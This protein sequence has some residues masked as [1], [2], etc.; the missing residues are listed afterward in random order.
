[1]EPG[2]DGLI[3]ISDLSWTEQINHP[4]EIIDK[5]EEIDVVILA[6][7]FENRRITLGHK[8]V[9]DNPWKLFTNEHSAENEDEG[10]VA[11]TTAKG[12][13]VKLSH[14]LE[15]FLSGAKMAD[16][17][18]ADFSEGDKVEAFV[19]ELDENNKN[20]TLSQ[21]EKDV[22]KAKSSASK[23]AKKSKKQD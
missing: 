13:F 11:K 12:V 6:I 23:K 17:E 20:I 2:I 4:N 22:K 16:S 3:H 10:G 7:D 15:G 9:E 19:I 1:L 21:N 14:D 8:Q 5:D 18:P